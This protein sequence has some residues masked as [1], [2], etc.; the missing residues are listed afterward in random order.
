MSIAQKNE[1]GG[2]LAALFVRRPVLAMVINALIVV[3][4]LAALLGSEGR[5]LPSVEQPV[6]SI[7]TQFPGAA[8]ET[9]DREIT[10]EVEGAVARV[11]GVVSISS[12]SS[13]GRS[14][15]TLSFADGT[16][17]DNATSD[18]RDAT[19]RLVS[20]FPDGAEAPVIIK[21]DPDAQAIMQLSVTSDTMNR[22]DLTALVNDTI[23]ERLASVAGVADVQIYGTQ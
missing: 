17:L 12:S 4:G 10:A 23:A 21:A 7:S 15:V 19:S 11:Q 22:A 2:T 6:L 5:E 18:V 1:R 14:R 8:A 9:V 13:Y 16:N 3:G 20:R